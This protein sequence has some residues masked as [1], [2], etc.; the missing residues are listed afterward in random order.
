MINPLF[1]YFFFREDELYAKSNDKCSNT[2]R[3]FLMMKE[4]KENAGSLSLK[5]RYESNNTMNKDMNKDLTHKIWVF[6]SF[7]VIYHVQ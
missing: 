4:L 7:V 3:S 5:Y 1:I 2:F 6:Y